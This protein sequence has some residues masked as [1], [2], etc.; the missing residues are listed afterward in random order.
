MRDAARYAQPLRSTTAAAR[1]CSCLLLQHL[2][3]KG[4]DRSWPCAS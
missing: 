4:M 1:V 2:H 3:F